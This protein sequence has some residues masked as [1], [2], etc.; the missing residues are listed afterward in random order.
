VGAVGV[1]A[2][3]AAGERVFGAYGGECFAAAAAAVGRRLGAQKGECFA[4]A[5]ECGGVL[6][7]AFAAGGVL[8]LPALS[9]ALELVCLGL[10]LLLEEERAAAGWG[11]GPGS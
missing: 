9:D 7:G 8:S 4:V 1:A 10:L 3:A 5:A 6:F 11:E 2:A